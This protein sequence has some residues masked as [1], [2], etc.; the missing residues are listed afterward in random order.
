MSDVN[1]THNDLITQGNTDGNQ[2]QRVNGRFA[3]GVSGNPAGRPKG[4]RNVLSKSVLGTYAKEAANGDFE[5]VMAE[6]KRDNPA[7]YAKLLNDAA[8]KEAERAG[9]THGGLCEQ[10]GGEL[11][12]KTVLTVEF[13]DVPMTHP[14]NQQANIMPVS[15]QA[16]SVPTDQQANIMPTN[17]HATTVPVSQQARSVP[18]DQ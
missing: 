18:T 10:C 17:E 3:K 11:E 4:A 12:S 1:S 13:V 2:I 7:V 14:V 16:T 5:R 8:M 15:Q 6:L 9:S